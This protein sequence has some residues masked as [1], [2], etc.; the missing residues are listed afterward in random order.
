[1]KPIERWLFKIARKK[2]LVIVVSNIGHN[3]LR[4]QTSMQI[5][6]NNLSTNIY[7]SWRKIA[8]DVK[9]FLVQQK[10]MVF[11]D[12]VLTVPS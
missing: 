2:L 10:L 5:V 1:M 12:F 7:G 8:L 6:W 3:A 11:Q 4:P 9:N